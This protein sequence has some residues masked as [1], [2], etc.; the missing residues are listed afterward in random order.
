MLKRLFA[1][2]FVLLMFAPLGY[3]DW[4]VTGVIDA[5]KDMAKAATLSDEEVKSVALSASEHYDSSNQVA[6]T[7]SP[8]AERLAKVT[9]GMQNEEGLK[10][11]IK[12]YMKDE[13]NAFAMANGSI[14][15]YSGLMDKMTDD[16]IRYV[17][18]HEIGHVNLGHSKKAL[19]VAYAASAGRKAASASGSNAVAAL[20]ESAMGE[21]AEKLVSAQFSQS[22]ERDADLYALKLMK[23]NQYDPKAT[24]SALRKLEKMFG[25]QAGAFA[26]HPAPGDR[27]NAL[28]KAL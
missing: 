16:E 13:I 27:A 23:L 18:G 14:R 1:M 22:Q 4:N 28:E 19:Q 9:D 12:V 7:P 21:L 25:N 8:Y 6:E 3:A 5:G 2:L 26:S 15:V 10:P 24:V 11:D 20:S 17:I